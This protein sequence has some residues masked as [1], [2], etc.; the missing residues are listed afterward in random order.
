M[1][2]MGLFKK[3]APNDALINEFWTWFTGYESTVIDVV[4][5]M[6]AK[7]PDEKKAYEAVIA[8]S[9]WMDQICFDTKKVVA[10][11]FGGDANARLELVF[12]P[13]NAYILNNIKRM[14]ELMPAALKE[15]WVIIT[16]QKEDLSDVEF[17]SEQ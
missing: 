12:F 1:K 11:K 4:K 7:I 13:A 16:D 10:F 3:A 15:R 5:G 6:N 9:K 17:I 8:L 2:N 14:D